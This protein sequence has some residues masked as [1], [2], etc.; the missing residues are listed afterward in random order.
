M[1]SD[2]SDLSGSI[3]GLVFGLGMAAFIVAANWKVFTKAGQPGW[4]C[5]VPIYNVVILSKVVQRPM[6]WLLLLF[7]PLAGLV[8]ALVMLFDLAK[9]FG[10]GAAFGFGLLFLPFIF[11]P[12]LAFGE[13]EYQGRTLS[14]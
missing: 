8:V 4:A 13:S 7:I 5:L 2:V 10:K 11:Y 1:Q 6:W 14:E 3:L 12:I 9:V